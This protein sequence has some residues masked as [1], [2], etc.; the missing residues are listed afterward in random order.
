MGKL[1]IPAY[2]LLML[3]LSVLV[4]R[5]VIAKKLTDGEGRVDTEKKEIGINTVKDLGY[6]YNPKLIYRTEVDIKR[7]YTRAGLFSWN[8]QRDTLQTRVG[9]KNR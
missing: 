7:T 3:T 5:F 6:E 4:G 1:V 8:I 2:M 9:W